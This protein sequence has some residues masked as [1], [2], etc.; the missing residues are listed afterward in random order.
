MKTIRSTSTFATWLR[1]L[2]DIN[3][4]SRILANLDKL[5]LGLGDVQP[6]GE[7]VSELRVN[8]GPGYRVYF[9]GRGADL[10]I[11]LCGGDKSS[12]KRDIK[13]AKKMAEQLE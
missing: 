8:V 5:A 13:E 1:G 7:G 11:L 3:G 9:V 4:R 10:I 6:V 12:Q 2:R